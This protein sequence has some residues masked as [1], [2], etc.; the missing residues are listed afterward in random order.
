[1]T[2]PR[3]DLGSE[4]VWAPRVQS[5]S[6]YER[7]GE[8]GVVHLGLGAF[9]RAHQA[10]VFDQLLAS[11]DALRAASPGGGGYGNPLPRDLAAVE[12][13]LNRGYISR[14]VAETVYGVVIAKETPIVPGQ[15]QFALDESAS[16]QRRR[17]LGAA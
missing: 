7:Q 6:R 9:H 16:V 5:R 3:L 14:Q 15:S 12:R 11:G 17:A 4:A 2:A 10:M 13:D 1:M 8:P